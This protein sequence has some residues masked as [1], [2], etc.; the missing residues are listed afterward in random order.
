MNLFTTLRQTKLTAF[1]LW[2]VFSFFIA[3][4][5][6]AQLSVSETPYSF[7]ETISETEIF[8]F[9]APSVNTDSLLAEDAVTDKYKDIPWR[10][11][12]IIPVSLTM[13]NAGTW[14]LLP[15][16]NKIWRLKISCKKALSINLNFGYFKIPDGASFYVYS[17]NKTEILGAFTSLNHNPDY[18][19]AT[20]PLEITDL[21]LEYNEP[22]KAAFPGTIQ[23]A[24]IVYGYRSLRKK[25]KGYLDSGP[26]NVNVMCDSVAWHN[27]MRS[28]VML[29]TAGNSRYCS[30]ALVNNTQ[31]DG[32]PYILTAQHCGTST[33]HIVMFGYCSANCSNT[34]DGPTNKT[35]QG[36]IIRASYGPS[37]FRLLE[38]LNT[39]PLNWNVFYAGWNNTNISPK[40]STGIHHPNGDVMKIAHDYDSAYS[41]G[42]YSQG[43]NHWM[44]ADWNTGTTEGGSSGS[45]L[46]NQL[47]QI[48][49]QLHGG[50]AACGNDEMDYYGKFSFSWDTDS[51]TAKQLKHWLDP[52]NTGKKEMEGFDP[53]GATWTN[54]AQALFIDGLQGKMCTDSISPTFYFRNN[55]QTNLTSLQIKYS[56]NGNSY[57]TI[58]WAGNISTYQYAQ[59]ALPKI[60][61]G[62]GLHK[63]SI[64]IQLPNG[65]ADAFPANDTIT[66]TFFINNMPSFVNLELNTDNYGSETTWEIRDLQNNLVASGGPFDDVNGGETINE[67]ICLYNGCFTFIIKDAYGDG[68]CCNFGN[69]S[70]YLTDPNSGDTLAWDNVFNSYSDSFPFCLGDSC[71]LFLSAY[72]Q[73]AT[74]GQNDGSIDLHVFGGSG[75]YSY[76]WSNAQ[77]TQD[78]S[79]I[80]TGSY[81]V[82]VTDNVY[83]C[84]DSLL[85]RIGTSNATKEYAIFDSW[86]IYPN[87]FTHTL[88]IE[89]DKE[90]IL[91]LYDISGKLIWQHTCSTNATFNIDYVE[92]GLYF[93]RLT[94]KENRHSKTYKLIKA[95]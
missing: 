70:F 43:N 37:D 30:G 3:E 17:E 41:T 15:N 50:N 92:M 68:Y 6:V 5:S 20:A 55:G 76:L 81:K 67:N 57:Y 82:I 18:Q 2:M 39:P 65:V 26:C 36:C 35:L 93:L 19:F 61:P 58:N 89:T 24:D 48:V 79:G 38:M 8:T 73:Y 88:N 94:D 7:T 1:F 25:A 83:G 60:A 64:H 42:Y 80:G 87:P 86:K 66:K 91:T 56:Y 21:I 84:K 40:A 11:G 12:H 54:D 32:K 4:K 95:E 10:F 78:I 16:G 72:V 85:V 13:D 28:V 14:H 31:N 27:E 23:V 59:V 74:L 77:T 63:L 44:V 49:G 45:P 53:N 90:T 9:L 29:L 71:Q 51:D 33:N 34:Q 69:G 22:A 47:H 52:G 75:S 62:G 46:F